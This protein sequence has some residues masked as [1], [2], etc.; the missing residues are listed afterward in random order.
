MTFPDNIYEIDQLIS[1]NNACAI[2]NLTIEAIEGG[3]KDNYT[4]SGVETTITSSVT[5]SKLTIQL[6]ET[7]SVVHTFDFR[8]NATTNGGAFKHSSDIQIVS[9]NCDYEAPK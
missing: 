5:D 1:S 8:I 9:V 3:N 4:I 7:E 2:A 6:P